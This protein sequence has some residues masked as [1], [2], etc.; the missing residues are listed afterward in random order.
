MK[1]WINTTQILLCFK[2]YYFSRCVM[3]GT[4]EKYIY[5]GF[6]LILSESEWDNMSFSP[7]TLNFLSRKKLHHV[8]IHGVLLIHVLICFTH[9]VWSKNKLHYSFILILPLYV[10]FLWFISLVLIHDILLD[11]ETWGCIYE[12]GCFQSLHTPSEPSLYTGFVH[13]VNFY[14]WSFF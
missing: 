4:G 11:I 14:T 1:V 9:S 7:T 2:N 13:L 12:L 3:I 10:S 6:V 8:R 5:L